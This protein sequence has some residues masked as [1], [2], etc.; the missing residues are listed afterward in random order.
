MLELAEAQAVFLFINSSSQHYSTCTCPIIINHSRTWAGSSCSPEGRCTASHAPCTSNCWSRALVSGTELGVRATQEVVVLAWWWSEL[1]QLSETPP[2]FPFMSLHSPT[3]SISRLHH[4]SRQ[5]CAH[6]GAL[7]VYAWS[8]S[9][10]RL[11]VWCAW[12]MLDRS[13]ATVCSGF[14]SLCLSLSGSISRWGGALPGE[15]TAL[16]TLQGEDP[17]EILY[18]RTHAQISSDYQTSPKYS[19]YIYTTTWSYNILLIS[20]V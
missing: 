19:N 13:G 15:L 17:K 12:R 16:R 10:G 5:T 6:K 14:I 1:W 8:E 11:I 7:P 18:S 2:S 3:S 4:T 9:V 20:I